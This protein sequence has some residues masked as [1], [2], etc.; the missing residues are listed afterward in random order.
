MATL[1]SGK[2]GDKM[3][4][5][6]EARNKESDGFRPSVNWK[7]EYVRDGKIFHTEEWHNLVT[8]SG[9]I[10][11]LSVGLSNS[12][13]IKAPWFVGLIRTTLTVA[14]ADTYSSHAGWTEFSA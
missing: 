2:F 3:K 1:G 7:A 10:Y 11:L 6:L 5:G 13:S 9:L 14:A 8:N 4:S 12:A